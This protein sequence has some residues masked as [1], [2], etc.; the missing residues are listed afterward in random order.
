[1]KI[2]TVLWDGKHNPCWPQIWR[3]P[4]GDS[5]KN[6]G[7]SYKRQREP[8]K[9]TPVGWRIKMAPMEK[10][11]ERRERK[12]RGKKERE[13]KRKRKKKKKVTASFSKVE[14]EHENE[15]GTHQCLC[16][17]RL[18]QKAPVPQANAPKSVNKSLSHK[19]LCF[20]NGCFCTGHWVDW[21]HS[22]A[23]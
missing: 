2:Y 8:K 22:Q 9:M 23:P 21:V 4:L 6:Q 19:V 5:S 3:C 20:S 10:K 18:S 11:M 15:N 17:W 7:P 13:K 1:M 14:R 16:P 12:G